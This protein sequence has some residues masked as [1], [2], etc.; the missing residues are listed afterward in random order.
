[1]SAQFSADTAISIPGKIMTKTSTHISDPTQL[2]LH[3]VLGSTDDAIIGL[4]GS[5]TI[6]SW[7]PAARTLF[8]YT[9]AEAVGKHVRLIMARDHLKD[10]AHVL[11]QVRAGK[12]VRRFESVCVSRKD[13]QIHVALTAT[14]LRKR[15][16][17]NRNAVM[18]VR[19]FS[20]RVRGLETIRRRNRELLSFY[21]LSQ[22]ILASRP[23]E[24]SYQAI[25]REICLA[26]GFP[27]VTIATYDESREVMVFRGLR[28]FPSKTNRTFIAVPVDET[29][30]GI[31]VRTGK[32]I[33]ESRML[34]RAE[35]RS[36]MMRWA[37]AQTY[38]GYPMKCNGR[39]IGCLNLAHT[40]SLTINEDTIRWIEAL[41][42]Y[43]AV[44][45][46]R[47]RAEDEL[48]ESREQLRELSR[49]TQ[50]AI[51][52]ERKRIAREIH[53]QLGQELS[54][55]QLEL[56]MMQDQSHLTQKDLRPR[57][58]AMSALIESSIRTVQ[59]I[60]TDLRPTLLDNLGLGAAVEW[61]AREFQ[62]RTRIRCTIVLEPQDIKLDQERSTAIF[63]ILQ[64]ALTNV[65]RHARATRVNVRL[66]RTDGA[67]LLIVRDNGI[68][69]KG[70]Q[71]NDSKSV[72]LTGMRERVRPWGGKIQIAGYPR[73]GTEI[74]ISVPAKS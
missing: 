20:R 13:Q 2:Q 51:E 26:T 23:L 36:R 37:R 67:I 43:V 56:G 73:K 22:I 46:E 54:L 58:K 44:L 7:N 64:E 33:I 60:S 11:A 27:I 72:G 24:E 50:A 40:E 21:R 18:I 16:D 28:G 45:T 66:V 70:E 1:M 39:I 32:P 71:V 55:I 68:G 41:A 47:R 8:G 42:N 5:G 53:D 38:V 63:R 14:R 6:T 30:S 29:V 15:A 65:L 49:E 12:S 52:E 74:S 34:S 69:I 17:S 3:A 62:K 31:I 9:A 19:D 10:A 35:F 61:A 59:R 48:R 4:A 25:V 57:F